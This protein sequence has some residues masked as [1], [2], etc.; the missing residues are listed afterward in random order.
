MSDAS[1]V[2]K[3]FEPE[4]TIELKISKRMK[5]NLKQKHK[6]QHKQDKRDRTYGASQRSREHC[7]LFKHT[8]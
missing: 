3:E 7:D 4:K 2:T 1:T 6:K 5:R 8:P